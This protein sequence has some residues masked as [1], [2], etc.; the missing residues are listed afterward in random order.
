[1]KR[2]TAGIMAT[3]L[4]SLALAAPLAAQAR[5]Y[6]GLGGGLSIPTG[7]FADYA[8]TGWLGQVV[9][10]ITGPNGRIGGRVDGYFLKHTYD[11]VDDA[12]VR[13][14]GANAD[15]V[16]APG[17]MDAK[18]RPYLPGGIGIANGKEK[19]GSVESDG[20]TK[21]SFN[22]GA[23]LMVKA[24]ARMSLYVEGRWMSVRTDDAINMIPITV[25]LRIGGQ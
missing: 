15:L 5:G 13:F 20:E 3:G 25:G 7:N 22:A 14:L 18:V 12:S 17:A 23:G 24:G 9:A 8:K 4:L 19:I 6:V 21:F 16:V 2:I 10:G 1:M 11:A